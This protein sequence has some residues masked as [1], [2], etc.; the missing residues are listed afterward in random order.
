MLVRFSKLFDCHSQ[1][2]LLTSPCLTAAASSTQAPGVGLEGLKLQLQNGEDDES[3]EPL[4]DLEEEK[5]A[6]EEAEE[7]Y[8]DYVR[9]GPGDGLIGAVMW[10]LSLPLMIPMW[11][12]IPDP[13]DKARAKY[14]PLAFIMSIVWIAVFSYFMVWWA[15]LTGQAL[16]I[17]YCQDLP[18]SQLSNT[19]ICRVSR[20]KRCS[21]L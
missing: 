16:G 13:Q 8:V 11:V 6:D 18:E 20:K 5:G 14:W 1:H 12:S 15:T 17:R 10:F 4:K 3:K 2:A 9:A 19:K 21:L 7:E